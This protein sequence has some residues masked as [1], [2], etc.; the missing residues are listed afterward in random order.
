M[1]IPACA[2]RG[3]AGIGAS[4]TGHGAEMAHLAVAAGIGRDVDTV[5]VDVES[6][7]SRL[8]DWLAE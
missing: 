3:V 7:E 1:W 2:C 4:S 6:D 5:L 8:R